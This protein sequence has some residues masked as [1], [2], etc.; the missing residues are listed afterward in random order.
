MLDMG[1]LSGGRKLCEVPEC[2]PGCCWCR[3]G[4]VEMYPEVVSS[5]GKMGANNSC[6]NSQ[7]LVEGQDTL[8]GEPGVFG[9]SDGSL[10]GQLARF[11]APHAVGLLTMYPE[12]GSTRG[13]FLAVACGLGINILNFWASKFCSPI[14]G[15]PCY[16]FSEWRGDG[17]GVKQM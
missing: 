12:N 13:G 5:M 4:L 3:D 8:W 2:F 14:Y 6:V 17:A 7:H 11:R 10:H 16:P 9:R 15:Q 1:W